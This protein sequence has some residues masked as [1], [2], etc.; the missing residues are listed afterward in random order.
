VAFANSVP[1]GRTAVL[2][3]G[4][5]DKGEILGV[6]DTDSMQKTVSLVREQCYPPIE[7]VQMEVLHTEAGDVIAVLVPPS[8]NK[9]HFAG[10]AF[11]R[12]GSRT[13]TATEAMFTDLITARTNE[14]R[15]LL[16]YK[17]EGTEVVLN[18]IDPGNYPNGMSRT[19][20]CKVVECN[21]YYAA[22][23]SQAGRTFSLSIKLISIRLDNVTGKPLVTEHSK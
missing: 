15:L 19:P 18:V 6:D 8:N 5:G 4:V 23:K 9:P 13:R 10:A 11:V 1:E 3:I 16:R 22:F 12:E 17:D 14:G 2:F 21:P 7:G 20:P